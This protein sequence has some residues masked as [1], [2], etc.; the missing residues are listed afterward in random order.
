MALEYDTVQS[1]VLLIKVWQEIPFTSRQP[2]GMIN[3]SWLWVLKKT[4]GLTDL[5]DGEI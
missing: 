5:Q 4:T 3:L 1:E 2:P